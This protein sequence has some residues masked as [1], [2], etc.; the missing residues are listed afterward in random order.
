M[1]RWSRPMN[2][3][4]PPDGVDRSRRHFVLGLAAG[5]TAAGLGL[6]APGRAWSAAGPAMPAS[7]I[8]QLRGDTFD[9]TIGETPVDFTGARRIATTINGSLP[10]PVLRWREG[11]TVTLRVT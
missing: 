8:P 11:D 4:L 3:F 1:R 5:G 7:A 9:L 2:P 6:L 10:G